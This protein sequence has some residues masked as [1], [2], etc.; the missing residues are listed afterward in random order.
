MTVTLSFGPST[1]YHLPHMN[2]TAQHVNT[3]SHQRKPRHMNHRPRHD[4][5]SMDRQR[6]V[7]GLGMSNG[8]AAGDVFRWAAYYVTGRSVTTKL[9]PTRHN[10]ALERQRGLGMTRTAQ[11]TPD[12]S[13]GP[14]GTFFFLFYS[15]FTNNYH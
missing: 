11:T 1:S 14:F 12:A 13:F 15:Y 3:T 5:T 2:I 8:R 7:A 9:P 6:E 10:V 4:P